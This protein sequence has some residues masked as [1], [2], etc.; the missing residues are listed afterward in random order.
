MPRFANSSGKWTFF[1]GGEGGL[2]AQFPNSGKICQ[3]VANQGG[4]GSFSMI[5]Q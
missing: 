2:L 1:G 3:K 5:C 4:G